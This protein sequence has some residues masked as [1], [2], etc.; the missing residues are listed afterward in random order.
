MAFEGK[1]SFKRISLGLRLG[2]EKCLLEVMA[3]A[4]EMPVRGN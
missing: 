3:R 1:L 2:P 4:R